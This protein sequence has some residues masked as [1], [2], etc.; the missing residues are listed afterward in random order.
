MAMGENE[1]DILLAALDT[2]GT[3]YSANKET[4]ASLNLAEMEADNR[5]LLLEMQQNNAVANTYLQDSLETKRILDQR[6]FELQDSASNIGL[7]LDDL[8]KISNENKSG[9]TD[10][11]MNP[12][13]SQIA[14]QMDI[15]KE[16]INSVSNKIANFKRGEIAAKAMDLN[17]DFIVDENELETYYQSTGELRNPSFILG[18]QSYK[19]TPDQLIDLKGK[20]VAVET[21][22]L[23]L[24]YLPIMLQQDV[25]LANINIDLA[26][27]SIS[28]KRNQIELLR[29]QTKQATVNLS[30]SKLERDKLSLELNDAISEKDVTALDNTAK[31]LGQ[32]KLNYKENATY[33]A[34][35]YLS[36]IKFKNHD[37]DYTDMFTVLSYS[38]EDDVKKFNERFKNKNDHLS[39]IKDEVYSLYQNIFNAKIDGITDASMI[40]GNHAQKI[41]GYREELTQFIR[42][43]KDYFKGGD[44]TVNQ[45][46]ADPKLLQEFMRVTIGETEY[47][48]EG[49][50]YTH[51]RGQTQHFDTYWNNKN[52][53]KDYNQLTFLNI[54]KGYQYYVSGAYDD[55]KSAEVLGQTYQD[56]RL[57]DD[58]IL[59]ITSKM[60]DIYGSGT[61]TDKD[62]KENYQNI[63][64]N[65]FNQ[66]DEENI[67]K[68]LDA[69]NNPIK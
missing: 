43:N 41:I 42:N 2:V 9:N 46:Y 51:S 62:F 13:V 23:K 52:P 25:N 35:G 66:L 33:L 12:S 18:V 69:I 39:L 37:G 63:Y 7:V 4:Q 6:L 19:G 27:L 11:I 61:P 47:L 17:N 55:L 20:Q 32:L 1:K 8:D 5:K 34:N 31:N 49:G 22:S 26:D 59:G 53:D 54:K 57:L 38:D 44:Y 24:D 50:G 68:A 36:T 56:I 14:G 58:E 40:A 64:Y 3:I 21:E 10:K 29:Q 15:T 60:A 16:K 67:K 45:I 28:E 30:I 65:R 48:K